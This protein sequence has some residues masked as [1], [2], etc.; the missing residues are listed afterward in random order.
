MH[1][2]KECEYQNKSQRC[3]KRHTE[4]KHSLRYTCPECSYGGSK[5]NL[6]RHKR[7]KHLGITHKCDQCQYVSRRGY[8]LKRHK[9]GKHSKLVNSKSTKKINTD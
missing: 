5:I 9:D 6:Q 4:N 7:D 1:E 3:F 8:E 2:C